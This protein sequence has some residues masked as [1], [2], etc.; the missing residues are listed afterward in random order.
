MSR[1]RELAPSRPTLAC[2]GL[3]AAIVVAAGVDLA[4][5][6]SQLPAAPSGDCEARQASCFNAE[7]ERRLERESAAEPLQDD[8][9]T[10]CWLYAV[11]IVAI[12]AAATAISLRSHPRSKWTRIFSNLG[13]IGVWVGIGAVALLVATDDSS[14]SPRAGPLLAIPIALLGGAAAG[15]LIA[16]EEGWPEESGSRLGTWFSAASLALTGLTVLLTVAFVASKGDCGGGSSQQIWTDP[17][18]LAATLAA[19]LGMVAAM[20]ALVQR[21]W[22]VP[23]IALVANPVALLLIVASTCAFL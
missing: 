5:T 15:T 14:I 8:Y 6:E 22:I 16:R 23:L 3:C 20:A 9:D 10:R 19:V 17:I 18:D 2:L 4:H 7:L 1:A 21:R 13:L 12:A 11:A